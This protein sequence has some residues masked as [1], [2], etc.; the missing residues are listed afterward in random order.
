MKSMVVWR[1]VPGKYRQAVE[2]FLETGGPLPDG[3]QR[4]GR[5]H[6]PGSILGWHLME[7]D[8]ALIAKHVAEWADV[9]ELEV[10]PV[11]EDDAA[12]T[13]AKTVFGK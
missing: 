8:P 13:A 11:I 4:L 10:Y 2:Q 5:W 12:G 3:V 1:T 6:V 9:L 7:G